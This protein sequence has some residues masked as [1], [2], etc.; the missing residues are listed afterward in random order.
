MGYPQRRSVAKTKK[1]ESGLGRGESATIVRQHL[2]AQVLS[3]LVFTRKPAVDGCFGDVQIFADLSH[4]HETIDAQTPKLNP[5][6][7]GV[8]I[9]VETNDFP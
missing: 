7:A 4:R 8:R 5:Q 2:F 3:N 6:Q 9:R 1:R